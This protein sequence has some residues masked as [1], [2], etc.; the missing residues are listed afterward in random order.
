MLS[1]FTFG[2]LSTLA[3]VT[4]IGIIAT[5]VKAAMPEPDAL[6]AML[7]SFSSQGLCHCARQG[8]SIAIDESAA[9]A[10]LPLPRNFQPLAVDTMED[11]NGTLS[12]PRALLV[13][14]RLVHTD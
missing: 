14:Y 11:W 8:F 4:I 3:V 2:F 12:T 10:C 5:A 6:V 7:H 9:G 13:E 1:K